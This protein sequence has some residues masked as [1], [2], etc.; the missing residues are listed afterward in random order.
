MGAPYWTNV[1]EN[2]V[3]YGKLSNGTY[4]VKVLDPGPHTFNTAVVSKDAMKI[5]VDPGETYFVEGKIA[6][7]VIGYSVIMAP[8]DEARF[9]KV[10][11]GMKPA[12]SEP[13]N[14]ESV[15]TEPV[16]P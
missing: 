10:L 1:R 5:E 2:D 16:A 11:K 13:A 14:P 6:M 7:A 15:K 3:A 12:K 4:F 8:S 9:Q